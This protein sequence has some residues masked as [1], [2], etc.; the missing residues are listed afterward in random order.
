[1]FLFVAENY[2]YAEI[3]GAKSEIRGSINVNSAWMTLH[4]FKFL[5]SGPF[6]DDYS[7]CFLL[8]S[9]FAVEAWAWFECLSHFGVFLNFDQFIL[10]ANSRVRHY[11]KDTRSLSSRAITISSWIRQMF[12]AQII[13][14]SIDHR[15]SQKL[16]IQHAVASRASPKNVLVQSVERVSVP[17]CDPKKNDEHKSFYPWSTPAFCLTWATPAQVESAL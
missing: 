3:L 2:W 6:W 8:A 16:S 5:R 4:P 14:R 12:P 7:R 11:L 10:S 15:D 9:N 1:M 13:S 17:T